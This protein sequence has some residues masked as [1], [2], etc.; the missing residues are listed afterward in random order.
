[1]LFQDT[2]RSV[3][4]AQKYHYPLWIVSRFINIIP[5][6]SKLFQYLESPPRKYIRV[7]TLKAT[8]DEIMERLKCIGFEVRKSI[9]SDVLEIT[10]EPFSLGS[11][12]EHLLGYFYIQDLSSCLAVRELDASDSKLVLDMAC[13]PGG[14]TTYIAQKMN[15]AGAL[16][17]VDTSRRRIR[18]TY[19]NLMRCGI[20][21]THLYNMDAID[22]TNFGVK[23][24]RVLLDAPCSCEG[25]IPRDRSIKNRHTPGLIDRCAQRQLILLD[26]AIRV[27]R[28]GGIVIY[29]TCTFAPEEN[30]LVVNS[31]INSREGIRIE[32]ID[33]GDDGLTSFSDY[34]LDSTLNAT[35]RLYPHIHGT[36]GFY[37]A[38]LKIDFEE[39]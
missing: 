23:F 9:L 18:S 13:A 26:T 11:T 16:I 5:N 10:W 7:N 19:F 22:V 36:L 21:N 28:P 24:D 37:I 39:L 29:S 35:K 15:N 32:P 30:E 12:V 3:E 25:V 14:K 6:A 17:A 38:K 20:Q 1:M 31:L 4:M 8:V 34:S 27:T 2:P 33:F